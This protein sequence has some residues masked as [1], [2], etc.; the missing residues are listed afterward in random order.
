MHTFHR[1]VSVLSITHLA[2]ACI[3]FLNYDRLGKQE[4]HHHLAG[5]ERQLH[6]WLADYEIKPRTDVER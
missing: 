2:N 4:V 3:N 5:G 6:Q 1:D